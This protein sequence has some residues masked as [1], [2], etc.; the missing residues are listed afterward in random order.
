MT[1]NSVSLQTESPELAGKEIRLQF[2]LFGAGVRRQSGDLGPLR[3]L[4]LHPGD[5]W[6]GQCWARPMGSGTFEVTL[7]TPGTGSCCLFLACPKSGDGHASIPCLI[8]RTPDHDDRQDA[9]RGNLHSGKDR[10]FDRRGTSSPS[11][12]VRKV[13]DTPTPTV[14]KRRV[15]S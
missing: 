10:L 3:A 7:P 2:K 12:S 4:V 1:R 13:V 6:Q 11:R 14:L 9:N 8:F 15:A 5:G